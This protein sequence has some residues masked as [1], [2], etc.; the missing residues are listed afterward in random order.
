MSP[1]RLGLAACSVAGAFILAGAASATPYPPVASGPMKGWT[2]LTTSK[3]TKGASIFATANADYVVATRPDGG[4]S[5]SRFNLLFPNP[6]PAAAWKSLTKPG[7][8]SSEAHCQTTP[9]TVNVGKYYIFCLT[10]DASGKALFQPLYASSS[11]DFSAIG[12][13]VALGGQVT[14]YAPVFLAY[15]AKAVASYPLDF[16]FTAVTVSPL[17]Q[18]SGRVMDVLESFGGATTGGSGSWTAI[19]PG[20]TGVPGC[21]ADAGLCVGANADNTVT[22]F[23]YGG[24]GQDSK[25][26]TLGI[27]A[28]LPAG[29]GG[30]TAIAVNKAGKYVVVARGQD[31]QLYENL[32]DGAF[33][34]WKAE[35][36]AV[37]AKTLP[38]CLASGDGVT[39]VVEG[40]DGLL[41]AKAM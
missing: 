24:V 13:P 10:L 35:G 41:Y 19:A 36:G 11:S 31:G 7:V 22:V 17:G 8:A 9:D 14:P 28:A 6:I 40:A 37:M 29:L 30:E 21:T 34:G 12:V 16:K 15:G 27:S 25:T 4:L 18:L 38:S 3:V 39:C 23:H 26:I 33:S 32:L 2:T 5:I 20:F 1:I